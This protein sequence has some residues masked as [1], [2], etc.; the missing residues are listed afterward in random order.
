MDRVRDLIFLQ[1]LFT[2]HAKR[3]SQTEQLALVLNETLVDVVKLFN[4]LLDTILVQRKRLNR[5]DQ[6]ILQFLVTTFTAGR[7][8]SGSNQT[9]FNLL[10]LQL[11][12]LAIGIC[13]QIEC[14]HDLWAQFGF[15]SRQ[16][17]VG[18]ILVFFF[19]F[20]RHVTADIGNVVVI[21]RTARTL[22]ITR[23]FFFHALDDRSLLGFRSGISGFKVNDFTQQNVG[24]IQ[25]FTPDDDRLECQRAFAKP[26]NHRFTTGFNALCD[27][28]FAF[29]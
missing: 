12:Q 4:Q 26:C 6:L 1:E 2:T 21:T 18:F 28:D 17:Q 14:F 25:L 13:D 9:A 20:R 29:A 11:T 3:F 7:Q 16:R 8:I 24:F 15:H 23:L 10:V 19:L 5:L 27:G 22:V